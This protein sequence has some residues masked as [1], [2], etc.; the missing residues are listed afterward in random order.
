MIYSSILARYLLFISVIILVSPCPMILAEVSPHAN[1]KIEATPDSPMDKACPARNNYPKITLVLGGGGCKSLAQIGVL[2]ILE[3]NHI[4]INTIVGTSAGAIIGALYAADMPLSEIEEFALSGKLQRATNPN[5][6]LHIITLPLV[7]LIHFG[8]IYA[9]LSSGKKLEKFLRKK[10]P[11]DFANLKIPFI[12]VA[13]DLE[14]GNTCML[15][16]GDLC[17]AVVASSAVPILVRPVTLNNTIFVDGG[18]KANLPTNCAQLTGADLIIAVP[19]DSPIR[20]VEKR[21]FRSLG[22]LAI[23]I[24]DIMEVEI[25]KHRWEEADLVIYPDVAHTPGIT[26]DPEIIKNTIRAGEEATIKAL[27]K[28]N[29]LIDSKINQIT[30]K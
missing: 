7:K 6:P 3:K 16:S 5:V 23:R 27:P 1:E 26:R 13:T 14:S 25:D 10:L 24:T 19:A 2:R 15:E 28:L 18:I 11:N 21:K 20:T 8:N 29:Q 4:R 30:T 12:A 22:S 17:K 9:G